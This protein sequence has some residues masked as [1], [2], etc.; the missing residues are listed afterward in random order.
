[1]F[2]RDRFKL[3]LVLLILACSSNF[4]YAQMLT[5]YLPS[6]NGIK[7]GSSR[8]RLHLGLNT[9][10]V[11]EDNIFWTRSNLKSD[12]I[13]SLKPMVGLAIPLYE[14]RFVLDYNLSQYLYGNYSSQ[15]H[16]DHTAKAMLEMNFTDYRFKL[17]E[18]YNRFTNRSSTEDSD[19]IRQENNNIRVDISTMR[20]NRLGFDI[21]YNNRVV[22]YLTDA[23]ITGNL[24]YK[25]RNRMYHIAEMQYLY[26][27]AP[28]TTVLL[29]TDLGLI[30]YDSALSS[31]SYYLEGLL[32]AKG[33]ITNKIT[34]DLRAGYRYQN[35]E[36]SDLVFSDNFSS[37]VFRGWINFKMSKDDLLTLSVE[38][39]A[40]ES[41]YRTMNYYDSVFGKIVYKH[42]FSHKWSLSPYILY[43]FN[44]YPEDSTELGETKK[45]HDN[46]LITGMSLSYLM[47][48]WIAFKLA[49]DYRSRSS[50]FEIF[51]YKDNLFTFSATVGI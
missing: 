32:G 12:W 20:M 3:L 36:N 28:K 51:S 23:T 30:R 21:A 29:E 47:Q 34:L 24:R 9:S 40:Y 38:K 6:S 16:M 25:D 18:Y 45:R 41:T 42:D 15:N 27:L 7:L 48:D 37:P 33:N 13:T 46:F 14:H 26:R 50:N 8:T 2:H 10:V 44:S 31:N 5:T 11:R 43:Q 1:M 4:L 35:Y 39:T 49:Y 17:E 19:Q 22:R